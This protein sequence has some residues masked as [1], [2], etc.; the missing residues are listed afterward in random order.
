MTRRVQY[1]NCYLANRKFF[2]ILC[3]M[4]W[5]FCYSIWPIH[6]RGACNISKINMPAYKISM[7]MGFKNVFDLCFALIG[8]MKIF[9]DVT[10]R[11]NNC[12]FAITLNIIS[13]FAK[14]TGIQLFYIHYLTIWCKDN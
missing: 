1:F 9:I 3:Y 10:E 6:D 14:A 5:K 13:S 8:K 2:T 12:C 4:H 11:V 7:E